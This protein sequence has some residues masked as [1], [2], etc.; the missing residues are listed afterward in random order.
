MAHA[1]DEYPAGPG[2][3]DHACGLRRGGLFSEGA[4]NVALALFA[5]TPSLIANFSVTTTD[6]IGALF[7]FLA[8]IPGCVVEAKPS[9]AADGADG[10]GAWRAV[11]GE[12]V[13]ASEMLLALMLMAGDASA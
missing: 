13:H 12:A 2:A 4:A 8:A 10:T 6:G 7:V 5:F 9:R 3:G 11:A 1:A